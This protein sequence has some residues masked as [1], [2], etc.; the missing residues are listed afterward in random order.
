[1]TAKL[2]YTLIYTV[3]AGFVIGCIKCIIDTYMVLRNGIISS[4]V[5]INKDTYLKSQLIK[6][7]PYY[8]DVKYKAPLLYTSIISNFN[9]IIRDLHTSP[10][11]T[12]VLI[13]KQRVSLETLYKQ[14]TI[15]SKDTA[16]NNTFR[17]LM[18]CLQRY[19]TLTNPQS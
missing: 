17:G 4:Y 16:F 19:H 2:F 11:K 15:T 9:L 10:I 7:L 13:K 12:R 6:L 14:Q 5:H 1:M 3:I 18:Q 8:T